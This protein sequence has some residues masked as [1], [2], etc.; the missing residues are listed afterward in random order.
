MRRTIC[1]YCGDTSYIQTP[2]NL[3]YGCSR[4][5]MM[6]CSGVYEKEK[7][8][9]IKWLIRNIVNLEMH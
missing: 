7:G 4:G 2:S 8:G 6:D 3:C 9:D 5:I 1:S